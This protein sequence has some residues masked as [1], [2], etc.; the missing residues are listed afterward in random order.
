MKSK[1]AKQPAAARSNT[2]RIIGQIG[3]GIMGGAFARHL[4][5]AGFEVVGFDIDPHGGARNSGSRAGAA[6]ASCAAVAARCGMLITSLPSVKACEAAFFGKDGIVA[7]AKRGTI[8][9]E[10]STC[11]SNVKHEICKSAARSTASSCSTARSAA[12]ARRRRPRTRRS[13]PAATKAA[14]K[15]LQRGVR[16]VCAQ[17]ALLRC[18]R[19]RH[20]NSSSSPTCW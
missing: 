5:A 2:V 19:Q 10:T 18:V 17:H 14:Y 15:A 20:P 13:M 1:T 16:R 6:A 9:I 12:P 4:L 11:R 8:V 7:K 3:L